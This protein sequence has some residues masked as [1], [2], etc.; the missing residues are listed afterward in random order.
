M[1]ACVCDVCVESVCL[2]VCGEGKCVCVCV[3]VCVNVC[4]KFVCVCVES[5]DFFNVKTDG[6]HSYQCAVEV[7][8]F[9]I[10]QLGTSN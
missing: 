8:I 2:C 6:A 4:G 3:C 5:V 7:L 9:C 10:F 1:C